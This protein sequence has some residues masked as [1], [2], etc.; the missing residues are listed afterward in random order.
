MLRR[1]KMLLGTIERKYEIKYSRKTRKL[2][3]KYTGR[4]ITGD[5]FKADVMTFDKCRH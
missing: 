5:L 2:L 1:E 4:R 3:S